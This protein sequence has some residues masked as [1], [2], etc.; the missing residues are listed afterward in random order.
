MYYYCV[1]NQQLISVLNYE[2]NVPD[3][4]SVTMVSNAEHHH[5]QDRTWW[6]NVAEQRAEPLPQSHRDQI[7]AS[8]ADQ[9]CRAFLASSDWQVLRHI[10]QLALGLPTSL[11]HEQYIELER[12]RESQARAISTHTET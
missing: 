4:V 1:E 5:I 8:L 2:P 7:D 11:T 9:Q 10:R 6:F 12:E 3:S